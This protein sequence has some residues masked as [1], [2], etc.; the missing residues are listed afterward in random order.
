[1]PV[2]L[3]KTLAVLSF[4]MFF[5]VGFTLGL[6]L[7]PLARV[8]SVTRERHRRVCTWALERSYPLFLFWMKLVLLIDYRRI[9]LPHDLPK[10]RAYVLIANH[11]SLIDVLFCMGWFDGLIT[12]VKA[13][14][15][16]SVFFRYVVRSTLYVP[17]AG[18][19][20][21]A[22]GYEP[23]LARMVETLRAGRPIVA[24]PEGTR[25][26]PNTL[27][28]FQRGPFEAAARAG[29]PL[30][31]LFI[32]MDNPGLTK[33][34]PLPV[35]RMRYTFDWLP[36]VDCADPKNEPRKLKNRYHRLYAERLAR[37]LEE[38]D[39]NGARSSSEPDADERG[40]DHVAGAGVADGDER[41]RLDRGDL[42]P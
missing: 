1:M 15:Y 12:V 11:P 23:V 7:F 18:L 39:S 25:S 24:F 38:R 19:T 16:E 21:D 41:D 34:V 42:L 36:W 28:K 4:G 3:T 32:G 6:V 22:D 10:D 31:P 14:W 37:H 40:H 27:L 26:P 29:V 35:A 9:E 33:G 8:L 2:W 17:G 20:G 13:S 30:V 5:G